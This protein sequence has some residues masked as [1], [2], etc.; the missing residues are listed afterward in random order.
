[1]SEKKVLGWV[2]QFLLAMR[3]ICVYKQ[4]LEQKSCRNMLMNLRAFRLLWSG[5]QSSLHIAIALSCHC[6]ACWQVCIVNEWS[7]GICF[8]TK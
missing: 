6:P 3:C 8:C 4:G 7:T 5:I 1:M 2:K